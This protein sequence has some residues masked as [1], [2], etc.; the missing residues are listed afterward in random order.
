ML[1]NSL[2]DGKNMFRGDQATQVWARYALPIL[3][4]RVKKRKTIEFS[5]LTSALR[6]EGHFYNVLMGKVCAHISTTL[7]ELQQKENWD[8]E[9][10]RITAIVLKQD[11]KC[12][13]HICGLFTGDNTQQPSPEQLHSELECIFNYTKWDAVLDALSLR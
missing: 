6:L 4:K 1:K 3:V 8:G 7:A 13:P 12:S 9:I 10:P 5:E 2:N 11:N